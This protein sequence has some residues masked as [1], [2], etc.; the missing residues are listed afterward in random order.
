MNLNLT[1][2]EIHHRLKHPHNSVLSQNFGRY[3]FYFEI[4]AQSLWLK[5]QKKNVSKL[6]E[7]WYLNEIKT[8][9]YLNRVS[10]ALLLPFQIF[11]IQ[12]REYQEFISPML[13]VANSDALFGPINKYKDLDQ[14]KVVLIQ[15]LNLISILHDL[16]I[17]HA[18][19]KFEHFRIFDGQAKLIDFEQSFNCQQTYEVSNHG[20]PRYMA[21]ELFHGEAKTFS[22]DV[23][24]LGIIWLEWL[25]QEKKQKKSYMDWAIWHCQQ[26]KVH[27]KAEFGAFES[28]I[29]KMLMK[30]KASRL[31]NICQIK[32]LLNE[33]D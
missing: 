10:P 20:T 24:A 22:T 27:I 19:L 5:Q 26:Q 33:I 13:C 2:S 1:L 28:I 3:L 7:K 9:Q 15:S 29:Q 8:Y 4:D 31:V 25:N 23:Y 11:D 14:I 32:Q 18:D 30:N 12:E 21:P 6:H 17:V 16:N